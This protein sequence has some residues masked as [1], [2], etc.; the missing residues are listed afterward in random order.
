MP[1]ASLEQLGLAP[2]ALSGL[3]VTAAPALDANKVYG[4]IEAL[5][6]QVHGLSEQLVKVETRCAACLCTAVLKL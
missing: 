4:I 6:N 5:V 3:V 1:P 2:D